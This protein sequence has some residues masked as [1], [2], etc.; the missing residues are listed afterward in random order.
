VELQRVTGKV[1]DG[2]AQDRLDA[3]DDLSE[4]ERLRHVVV[5]ARAQRLDLVLGRVL[6]GEEENAGLGALRPE[7]AADLDCRAASAPEPLP[8]AAARP[9]LRLRFEAQ[10]CSLDRS[11]L[12]APSQD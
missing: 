5:A 12:G 7:A 3:R 8:S 11:G 9:G 10:L 2:S 1:P 6:G 4:A